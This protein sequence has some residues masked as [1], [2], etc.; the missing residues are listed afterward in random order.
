M[1]SLALLSPMTMTVLGTCNSSLVCCNRYLLIKNLF[2]LCQIS[3]EYRYIDVPY[4]SYADED[5]CMKGT[6]ICKSGSAIAASKKY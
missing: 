6:M 3:V 1:T 2:D 4:F 5:H